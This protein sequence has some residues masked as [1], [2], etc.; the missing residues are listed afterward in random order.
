MSIWW[1][2]PW[3]L[4]LFISHFGIVLSCPIGEIFL[5]VFEFWITWTGDNPSGSDWVGV[6]VWR[7]VGFAY[8]YFLEI[9]VFDGF[10][11]TFE[12]FFFLFHF[13]VCLSPLQSLLVFLPQFYCVCLHTFLLLQN[14]A[15]KA[16][17]PAF[18]LVALFGLF[19]MFRGSMFFL[20][21]LWLFFRRL[22]FFLFNKI[23]II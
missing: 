12:H 20:F 22:L 6:G 10:G 1:V 4:R 8:P 18:I 2:T 17:N 16:L 5:I 19:F 7:K 15:F 9:M 14:V 23:T 21:F 13:F 3:P 11:H